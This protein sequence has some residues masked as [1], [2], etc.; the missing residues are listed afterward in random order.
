M[1]LEIHKQIHFILSITKQYVKNNIKVL[2]SKVLYLK[3]RLHWNSSLH[4]NKHNSH[5]SMLL[6]LII[7][8]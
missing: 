3:C 5:P 4:C 8:E 6:H 1:S 7:W 2:K